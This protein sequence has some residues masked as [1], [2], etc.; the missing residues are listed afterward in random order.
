MS[1][2]DRSRE[3]IG[4]KPQRRALVAAAATA[5]VLGLTSTTGPAVAFAAD[6]ALIMGPSGVPV[7]P[8]SYVDAADNLYLVPNGY[9]AYTPQALTTPEQYYPVTGVNS[10]TPD[11]SIAQ[12]VTILND[13]INQQIAAGNNVVVFGYSQSSVVASQEMAQLAASSNP[14]SP[15]QLSFVL[16]GDESNPNGGIIERFE[17]PGAPLSLPSLGATFNDA[18]TASNTYPTA[19]YTQEYDGFADFPE[20]PI[21]LLS[22]LN[23]Y[24]GVF[25]QHFGY[26]DLTPQQISSAIA[27]PTTGN[28]T[29]QYYMVPTTDLP[30]LDP[31]RLLPIIGD[32]LA[33]LLQ[34][35]LTVLVNLGYGSITNGW[36]PGPANVPTPFGLF[37]TNINP[38]DVLAA[39][40]NGAVQG[41]T[42]A[43]NDLKSPQLFDTSSLSGLLAGL[44]TIG[45]TPS[46]NPSLLQLVAA[47]S[48]LGN[49]GVPVTSTG[50][51]LNTL[52]N[53]VSG[54]LAVGKPIADTVQTIAET[55]PEYDAQLFT[56]QL[57]A[58]NLLNAIGMPIAADLALVPY[59]LIFGAV[60][61][62]V[63]AA[64]STVTQLAELTGLEPNPTDPPA[65]AGTG[66]NAQPAVSTNAGA[67]AANAPNS[68]PTPASVP[69]TRVRQTVSGVDGSSAT[70]G[71]ADAGHRSG[72]GASSNRA[73]STP[74]LTGGPGTVVTGSGAHAPAVSAVA[75]AG[76]GGGT[77]VTG[78]SGSSGSTHST[79]GTGLHRAHG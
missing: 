58:G 12:G 38:A 48:T 6:T 10:L 67:D 73:P 18:P 32:P 9:S 24:V 79:A 22:D 25:T 39:L 56:S 21:D 49:E 72:N 16:V 28:T 77:G 78:T 68:A 60:F 65:S 75:G 46:N 8:Q 55:L 76:V 52:T 45:D 71:V 14:P 53:V 40:A 13:A 31:V 33:D 19:V 62:I 30:L 41:V 42:N 2:I 7:P 11:T 23:A 37:P 15:S 54:D 26:A 66:T 61:P 70:A 69:A 34:P 44:H 63:G 27:L 29:T 1:A 47:F 50:G 35:D 43:L 3:F 64:A 59:A 57:Q 5:S 17:V 20:Y 51:I 36:S 4:H 74:G